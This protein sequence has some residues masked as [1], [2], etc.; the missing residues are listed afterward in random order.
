MKP[1]YWIAIMTVVG[2]LLTYLI[3]HDATPGTVAGIVVG[4]PYLCQPGQER[5]SLI[6][7]N[8]P[9]GFRGR[10]RK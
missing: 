6:P 5:R 4:C 9:C 3:F 10:Q 1:A 7:Q 8:R 2:A